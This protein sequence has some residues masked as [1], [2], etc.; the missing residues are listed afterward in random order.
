[1]NLKVIDGTFAIV[2]LE[3]AAEAPPLPLGASGLVSVTRTRDELSILC[4]D[5]LASG[6]ARAHRGL[7][8]IKVDQPLDS[9]AT[10]VLASLAG[11][12]AE[13]GVSI[14]VVSTFDTDYVLVSGAGLE[15]A[16]AALAAAG[17]E[18]TS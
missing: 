1:M 16:R 7:R 17:H 9:G 10:G 3:P 6:F 4:P 2:R 18:F 15:R 13:A 8:A 5:E 14:F 12:L 11:P